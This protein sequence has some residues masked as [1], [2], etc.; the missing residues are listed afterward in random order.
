MA[1]DQNG[2]PIPRSAVTTE[3][4]SE[5][6]AQVALAWS[7]KHNKALTVPDC[8][9]VQRDDKGKPLR[10]NKKGQPSTD[11]FALYTAILD[12][13]G[14]PKPIMGGGSP[15]SD[16][17]I[18]T[19]NTARLSNRAFVRD[20]MAFGLKFPSGATGMTWI[21]GEGINMLALKR[22][23]QIPKNVKI[24]NDKRFPEAGTQPTNPY[25]AFNRLK[26]RSSWNHKSDKWNPADIW[27]MTDAGIQGL[28]RLNRVDRSLA[29]INT[30]FIMQYKKK[31]IFPISLKA[32]RK[33]GPGFDVVNTN[34]YVQRLVLGGTRNPTV[35]V[36]NQNQDMRINFSVETVELPKGVTAEQARRNPSTIRGATVK[37]SMKNMML[38]YHVNNNL[39]ELE[40]GQEG[41]SRYAAAKMGKIGYQSTV[42]SIDATNRSGVQKLRNI[43]SHHLKEDPDFRNRNSYSWFM[44]TSSPTKKSVDPD[45]LP[46]LTDYVRDIW[47]ALVTSG[48]GGER[49]DVPNA[50]ISDAQ[51]MWS[52]ARALELALAIG[53]ITSEPVK[54]RVIENLYNVAASIQAATGLTAQEQSLAAATGDNTSGGRNIEFTSAPYIKVY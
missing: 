36:M 34:E 46:Q 30:W 51:S 21:D 25:A 33:S 17:K 1:Y 27:V 49:P 5:I 28:R 26:Q 42:K 24:Y 41:V 47:E 4:G 18:L 15:F 52:K 9:E 29:M 48:E 19:Q 13:N 53:G 10:T 8:I 54:K 16:S 7:I 45:S 23:W 50:K 32:P 43:Q 20:V 22:R 44:A 38:K 39:L 11:K 6:I 40:P 3:V 35:Q 31:N 2:Q 14:K 37:G 12:V